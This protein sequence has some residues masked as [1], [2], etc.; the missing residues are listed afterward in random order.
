M[1]SVKE[2]PDTAEVTFDVALA[3]I[4]IAFVIVTILAPAAAAAM[5][6]VLLCLL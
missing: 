1:L 4:A 6:A 2:H 5:R 3:R